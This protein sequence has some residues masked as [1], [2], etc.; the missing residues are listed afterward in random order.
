ML[1]FEL[2][3]A[4]LACGAIAGFLAGLLGVGGGLI[5]VPVV[6]A[7]LSAAQLGGTHIQ[8]LAVGT[9]LAVMVFTSAS[10]VRAHHR[11]GAVDWRIVRGMAP[12]MVLGT[13]G[14]S[15]LA[16]WIPGRALAWFFV[17]YAYAVAAQ[18]L[19]GKQPKAG[20]EMPG[21]AGQGAAG[22]AIG[23]IS[24]WVGIG[25]GSMSVPF[26]SWCNVAMHRA[27]GTSAA[28]GWPIAMSG[29]LGYLA[30]G[31][32]AAGLPWGS[33]GYVYLPAML[34]LTL[35]TVAMAPLGARAAHRLPVARLKKAFALLMV[36][37][38]S[39]MLIRLL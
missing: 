11:K 32:R 20:R 16:G 10:S 21:W 15:L 2:F 33:V 6:V 37:M 39:E 25:G 3:A 36:V 22:G 24:S 9:S 8:H 19:I 35:M 27:I 7:V 5:I 12:A 17:I 28:L 26:M 18:M 34:T 1:S 14:G 38:A 29:A 4:L 31:W 23:M 13:L 30:S